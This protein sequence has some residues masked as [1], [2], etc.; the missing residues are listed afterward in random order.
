MIA[1]IFAAGIG[2]RLKPFTDSH[3]KALAPLGGE[4]VLVRVARKLLDAGARRII[5]NV[6]HFPQQIVDVLAAQPFAD[7]IEISDES[8]LLLDTGGAL[9]RIGRQSAAFASVDDNEPVVAHNADIYTD[10]PLDEMLAAHKAGGADATILVDPARSSTRHFLFDKGGALRGWENTAKGITRPDALDTA[11]LTA[12]AFGG[13]H[14]LSPAVV[15]RLASEPLRPFSITDWY[16]DR[17]GDTAIR[18]FTPSAPFH[19]H[20]I[21]TPEKLAAAQTLFQNQEYGNNR[22]YS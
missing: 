7:R 21:G 19:W 1:V 14:V 11:G 8:D 5:V 3:P 15:R 9:C 12:A 17:C 22:P 13:V 16:I 2:S 10:F 20:D 4:P 18:A 6:H